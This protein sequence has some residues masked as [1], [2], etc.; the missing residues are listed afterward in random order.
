MTEKEREDLQDMEL[1]LHRQK[2]DGTISD[3]DY[4]KCIVSLSYEYFR[5]DDIETGL[6]LL[7][8]CDCKYFKV[9]QLEQMKADQVY[10]Q[11]VVYI[12]GRLVEKGIATLYEIPEPTQAP[13]KA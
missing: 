9:V 4:C 11:R 8:L 3:D 12:A 13:A 6:M 2:Y 7:G 1:L 10:S 5:G